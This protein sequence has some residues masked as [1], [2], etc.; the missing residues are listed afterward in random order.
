MI[1]Q[2]EKDSFFFRKDDARTLFD[3][4]LEDVKD[5]RSVLRHRDSLQCN[6][7]DVNKNVKKVLFINSIFFLFKQKIKVYKYCDVMS[8]SRSHAVSRTPCG[9][10]LFSVFLISLTVPSCLSV[11]DSGRLRSCLA[12]VETVLEHNSPELLVIPNEDEL[13]IFTSNRVH[14]SVT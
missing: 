7:Y 11:E 2:N 8:C 12:T 10:K 5:I 3:S 1:K 13:S 4:S 6:E 14:I 9:L